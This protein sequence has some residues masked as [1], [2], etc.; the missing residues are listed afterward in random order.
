MHAQIENLNKILSVQTDPS[1]F[2]H[3][4]KLNKTVNRK[5]QHVVRQNCSR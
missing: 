1:Q 2:V 5:N 3:F 4:G